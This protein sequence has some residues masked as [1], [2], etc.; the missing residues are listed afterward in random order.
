MIRRPTT[1]LGLLTGLNLLNYIDRYVLSAVLPKIQDALHLSGFIAGSLGTVFLLGYFITSPFFGSLADRGGRRTW[2]IA[3][4]IVVWS[5]ATAA[6]GLA[7]SAGSLVAARVFV[8]VGEAAYATIAPTIID[9]IAPPERRGKWLAI[10]YSAIPIG[11]ALGF[12]IGGKVESVFGWRAA[13]FFAGGPGIVLAL[14]CLF[15]V[16]PPRVVAKVKVS[17]VEAF[18][19]LAP[20]FH[21]RRAVLGYCAGTFAVGGF[22]FWAPTFLYRRYAMPLDKANFMFGALTVVGGAI[23]TALGGWLG[24]RWTRAAVAK[25]G[26]TSPADVDDAFVIANLRVCALSAALATPAAIACFLSPTP[27]VFFVCVFVCE[28]GLFLSMSPIN[29][30]ILRSVPAALRA[31]AMALSIFAIHLLGDLWSPPLTGLLAD[32][33][34]IQ[35][36]M[37]ILPVAI[38]VSGVVWLVPDVQKRAAG[39]DRL[40]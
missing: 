29:A 35:W 21:Y 14:S 22:A 18:K 3:F 40:G 15:V 6:S 7:A 12:M 13:F 27:T 23:G 5:L 25:R 17:V 26:A 20:I 32:H 34:P 10:F 36:A 1:I 33:M 39:T 24:D 8:G 38:A 28:L 37:M 31:G 30:V 11:S 16:E 19:T 9:D 4:G 2:L